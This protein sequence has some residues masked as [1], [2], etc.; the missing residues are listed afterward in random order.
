MDRID[1][2]RI[3][4][5]LAEVIN[6]NSLENESNTPDYVLA[7]YL[8]SCLQNFNQAISTRHRH[9]DPYGATEK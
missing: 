4:K 9:R 5:E 1:R 3:V 2:Q 8:M 6:R 7:E